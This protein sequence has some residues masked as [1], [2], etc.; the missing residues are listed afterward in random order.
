MCMCVCYPLTKCR[1]A[2]GPSG[3]SVQLVSTSSSCYPWRGTVCFEVQNAGSSLRAEQQHQSSQA[4]F[5]AST[6]EGEHLTVL[7]KLVWK[8]GKPLWEF[9]NIAFWNIYIYIY[10]YMAIKAALSVAQQLWHALLIICNTSW[11]TCS[12]VFCTAVV[13][14][15]SALAWAT[16]SQTVQTI[17]PRGLTHS[18]PLHQILPCTYP[19]SCI[20]VLKSLFWAR[21]EPGTHQQK[22]CHSLPPACILFW[23]RLLILKKTLCLR[24]S[25]ACEFKIITVGFMGYVVLLAHTKYVFS[26]LSSF[27]AY[28]AASE[29]TAFLSFLSRALRNISNWCHK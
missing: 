29:F 11:I 8:R 5:D 10:I 6:W 23:F 25:S 18:Q 13:S 19:V 2:C 24:K 3:V 9:F 26:S 27:P 12:A 15:T 20:A 1:C 17:C 7:T 16:W 21:C 14:W 4:D 22:S 28:T